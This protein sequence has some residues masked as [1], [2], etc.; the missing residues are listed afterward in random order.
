MLSRQIAE[1]DELIQARKEEV[2]TLV[3]GF[4]KARSSLLVEAIQRQIE[5]TFGGTTQAKHHHRP[6]DCGT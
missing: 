4:R 6:R 5:G 2:D 3:R 1:L